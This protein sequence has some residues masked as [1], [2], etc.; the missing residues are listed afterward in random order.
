[1]NAKP[2][3]LPKRPIPQQSVAGSNADLESFRDIADDVIESD[4]V[5][6]ACLLNED[7]LVTK[8]GELV[9]TIK[10]TGLGFDA[11]HQ[12]DLRGVIRNAIQQFIPDDTYAIWLHTLRRRQQ[13][14]APTQFPDKF[15]ANVDAGWSETHPAGAS[16]VNELYITIVKAGQ[17]ATLRRFDQILQS[18]APKRESNARNAYLDQALRELTQTVQRMLQPLQAYGA[19]LLTMVE[20]QGEFY[21][22]Q[23]EFLEKLINLEERPMKVPMRDLSMVL[24]SGDITFGHNAMEV[25]TA[26]GHRRFACIITIKEYKES[27]LAGIDK[28]LDIPCELIV[29]QC[30]DFV[31]SDSARKDYEKQA[32]YLAI[33]GDREL[34][35]WMEISRLQTA[36]NNPRGFGEQ[37]TTLFLIANSVKNLEANVRLVQ[38]SLAKIGMVAVRED[39]RFEE[40]YWAQLPGNFPFITRKHAV[41]TQHLAGFATVQTQPMG[42]PTGSPWGP[43]VSVLTTVQDAPYFFNFH[44]DATAHTIVLGRPKTGRTSVTHFLLAQA[45]RLKLNIWYIDVHGRGAPFMQAMGGV[46]SKPGT[47][48]CQFNPFAMEDT[49][50]N[51]EFLAVW[52]TTLIDPEG[53]H[54]TQTTIGFFQSLIAEL[55]HLPREQR[56]LSTL[57]PIIRAQDVMLAQQFQRWCAGGEFGELFDMPNDTFALSTLSLFDI[58]RYAGNVVTRAPLSAYLLHRLTMALNGS[59]TLLVLDEGFDILANPLFGQRSAAWLDYF[60]TRGGAVMMMSEHIEQSGNYPFAPALAGRAASIFAM[61]DHAPAAEYSYGFGFSESDL[62]ALSYMQPALRHVLLKRGNQSTLLKMDLNNLGSNLTTLNGRVG[63]VVQKSAAD[64]LSELMGYGA[65]AGAPIGAIA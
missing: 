54:L 3:A 58:T 46:I 6:Y 26:E 4:F 27:T 40:C 15:S 37:Q 50:P 5:P 2:S 12:R 34:A 53:K 39:L 57:L 48:S 63:L 65:G 17:A 56:R 43:P 10:I 24:T 8:N 1:M 44:R 51:R 13:L 31:G 36:G 35:D 9:Q 41:D 28:F 25:R 64:T 18:L 23:L 38:K 32:R 60:A 22:E 14:V 52:L 20:R 55:M 33:S 7:T 29:T 19:R 47:A 30:F 11:Q 21:S 49:P 61:P 16:F 59:P 62:G 45:R 42:N